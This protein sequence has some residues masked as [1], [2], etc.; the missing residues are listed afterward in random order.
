MIKIIKIILSAF[1]K[2]NDSK[3]II[4]KQ[5]TDKCISCGRKVYNDRNN[6]YCYL[7]DPNIFD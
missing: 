7:C 5:V 3:N 6:G 1:I 4:N 2:N